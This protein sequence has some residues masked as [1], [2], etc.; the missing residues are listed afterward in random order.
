MYY[1]E[2]KIDKQNKINDNAKNFISNVIEA[3]DNLG[4]CKR[5]DYFENEKLLELGFLYNPSTNGFSIQKEFTIKQLNELTKEIHKLKNHIL[6]H[7]YIE[8]KIYEDELYFWDKSLIYEGIDTFEYCL[9]YQY[10]NLLKL[11]DL[12]V[13]TKS[14]T[15]NEDLLNLIDFTRRYSTPT[16]EFITQNCM[17]D[18]KEGYKILNDFIAD[19]NEYLPMNHAKSY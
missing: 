14:D 10:H 1:L 9:K 16:I 6:T 3:Q 12:L 5:L 11:N 2:V 7:G 8:L 17:W 18:K 15:I 13:L 4:K 19:K